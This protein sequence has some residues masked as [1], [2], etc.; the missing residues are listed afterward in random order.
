MRNN[1]IWIIDMG[2]ILGI[3][4][5]NSDMRVEVKIFLV[6]AVK[7]KV[8]CLWLVSLEFDNAPRR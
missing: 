6:K 8:E 2:S 5:W 7:Q 4:I 1:E 3:Q